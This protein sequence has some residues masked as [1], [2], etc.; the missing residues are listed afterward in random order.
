MSIFHWC[1][2]QDRD[3]HQINGEDVCPELAQLMSPLVSQDDADQKGDQADNG[4]RQDA[5][6]IDLLGDGP[7]VQLVGL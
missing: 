7:E 2:P 3:R 4:N 5:G 1:F 6:L